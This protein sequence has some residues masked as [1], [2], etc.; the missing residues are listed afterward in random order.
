[1]TEIH[2]T[3]APGFEAARDQFAKHFETG[4]ET[5]ASYAVMYKG[6]M[7]VDLWAGTKDADGTA[8]W[9]RDTIA[10]VWSTTKGVAAICIALLVDR[11][12]LSYDDKVAAHWPDFA[13]HGKGDITIAQMLSHQSGLSGLREPTTLAE[14]YDHDLIAARLAAQEP[15][16]EPGTRS[17][18]HAFTYGFLAGEI[19]KRVTGRS[20]G[21]FLQDEIGKPH[22]IDFFIGLPDSEEPRVAPLIE[23]PGLQPLAAASEVQQLTF[24][25]PAIPQTAPNDRAW[26]AA[27][28]PAAGGLGTASALARLYALLDEGTAP[29]GTPLISRPTMEALRTVRIQNEDLVLGVPVRWG[30]G[31]AMNGFNMYGPNDRAFGHTGWGGAFGCLDPEAG[32]AIGYVMNRMGAAVVGDP[33]SLALATAAFACI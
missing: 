23:A 5:G 8:P 7:V 9:Q 3:V 11:G 6:E 13:A 31:M 12:E 33:R 26:R 30:S 21:T 25:N 1:M 19:V 27:E 16:W 14:V 28:L 17:G 15:L 29:G 10:N 24:A 2:G 18:Y 32:L 20:L 4:E 22:G